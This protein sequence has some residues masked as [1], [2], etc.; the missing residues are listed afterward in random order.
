M[1]RYEHPGEGFGELSLMYGKPRAATIKA[2]T[3]G[4]LWAIN[5]IAFRACMMKRNSHTD[6]IQILKKV[7]ILKPLTIPQMQRLCD[8][9]AEETYESG[10]FIVKQ[11]E[12]G[13]NVYIVEE[14]NC[15]CTK[16]EDNKEVEMMRLGPNDYFG[17]RAL[18]YVGRKRSERASEASA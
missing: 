6:L 10:D 1:R 9:F 7:E 4:A 18:M 14:G 15:V 2:E 16:V 11:G 3:D 17:E 8:L 13:E 5:R 12:E